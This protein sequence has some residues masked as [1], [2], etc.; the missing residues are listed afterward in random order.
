MESVKL[1][2]IYFGRAD[3]LQ[4]SEEVNFENLFYKGNNKYSLL[5]ENKNKPKLFTEQYLKR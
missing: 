2:D 5:V 4:E 3:G 1:K